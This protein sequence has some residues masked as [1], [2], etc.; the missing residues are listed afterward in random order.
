MTPTVQNDV[1]KTFSWGVSGEYA[2]A[3]TLD[4]D[5][6]SQLPVGLGGRGNLDGAFERSGMFFLAATFNWKF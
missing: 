6:E 4:V 3:G 5:K 2:Y 1:S